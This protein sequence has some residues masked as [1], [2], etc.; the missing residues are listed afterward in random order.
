MLQEGFVSSYCRVC[1]WKAGFISHQGK[2]DICSFCSFLK[3]KLCLV[4]WYLSKSVMKLC[5]FPPAAGEYIV[6]F[7]A[8]CMFFFE[9]ICGTL[10]E[11][12]LLKIFSFKKKLKPAASPSTSLEVMHQKTANAALGWG[13]WEVQAFCCVLCSISWRSFREGRSF[14]TVSLLLYELSALC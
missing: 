12:M 1:G 5:R 6:R 3:N 9:S 8:S 7:K 13:C 11:E 4:K 2:F 14:D 10:P